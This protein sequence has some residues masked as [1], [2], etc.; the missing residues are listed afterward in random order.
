MKYIYSNQS[1]SYRLQTLHRSFFFCRIRPNRITLSYTTGT[2]GAKVGACVTHF[3][4]YQVILPKLGIYKLNY[5]LII[6]AKSSLQR[7]AI[8][9]NCHSNDRQKYKYLYGKIVDIYFN[10]IRISKFYTILYTCTFDLS[11]YISS[12]CYRKDC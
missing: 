4:V 1:L 3:I 2:I 10:Q 5:A 8:S 11:T 6:F 9:Y 12:N 7:I